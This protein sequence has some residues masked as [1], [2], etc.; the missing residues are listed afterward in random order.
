LAAH[1]K[2]PLHLDNKVRVGPDWFGS[3]EELLEAV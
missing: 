2:C 3:F 1:E